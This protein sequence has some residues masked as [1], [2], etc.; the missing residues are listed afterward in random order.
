MRRR[1]PLLT[2]ATLGLVVA[3][4]GT[5]SAAVTIQLGRAEVEVYHFENPAL[6]H[7]HNVVQGE[8][9]TSGLEDDEILR[10]ADRL[11][12]I[13]NVVRVQVDRVTLQQFRNGAWGN[14]I[15]TSAAVNSGTGPGALS[16]TPFVKLC[17]DGEQRYRVLSN[18]SA[19]W[20]DGYL[21]RFVRTSSEFTTLPNVRTLGSACL[22]T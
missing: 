17:A 14:V 7:A 1:A 6:G 18:L 2:L 19:R 11:S 21:S 22:E 4:A 13:S 10:G 20:T 3:L 12:K 8:L 5:A 16:K 15:A 9:V